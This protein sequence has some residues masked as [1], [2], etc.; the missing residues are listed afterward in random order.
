MLEVVKLFEYGNI[1]KD[2]I[3]TNEN[4]GT[5]QMSKSP[6]NSIR[7]VSKSLPSL[8]VIDNDTVSKSDFIVK[9]ISFDV[10]N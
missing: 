6:I 2:Y 5:C 10:K 1:V 8:N 9:T 4:I 7:P 3:V